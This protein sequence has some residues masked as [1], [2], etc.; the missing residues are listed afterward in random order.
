MDNRDIMSLAKVRNL[1]RLQ[2]NFEG[3]WVLEPLAAIGRVD[4]FYDAIDSDDIERATSLMRKAKVDAKTIAAVV[5][6]IRTAKAS[7]DCGAI[8]TGWYRDTSTTQR[9]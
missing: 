9:H 3:S 5:G 7:T 4:D 2:E 1:S 6:K 8:V